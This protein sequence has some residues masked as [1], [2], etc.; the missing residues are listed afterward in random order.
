MAKYISPGGL[1][2]TTVPSRISDEEIQLRLNTNVGHIDGNSEMGV[3][4]P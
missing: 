1:G 4:H 3:H 2:L